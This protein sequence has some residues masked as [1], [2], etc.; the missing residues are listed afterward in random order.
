MMNGARHCLLEVQVLRGHSDATTKHKSMCLT[1]F[2]NRRT[3]ISKQGMG[4]GK[5]EMI[6]L[7][8]NNTSN[9]FFNSL[10]YIFPAL[11][12]RGWGAPGWQRHH[13]PYAPTSKEKVTLP[14]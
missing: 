5:G 2:R 6:Y 4:G 11:S 8:E 7:T 1:V 10:L 13:R 3:W 9:I 12:S 14:R